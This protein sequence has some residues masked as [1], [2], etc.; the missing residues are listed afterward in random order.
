VIN[1]KDIAHEDAATNCT[2]LADH[3]VANAN[4]EGILG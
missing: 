3:V 2:F 4:G 1:L